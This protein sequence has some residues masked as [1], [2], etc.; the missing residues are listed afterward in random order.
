[1]G[2]SCP[3]ANK[4][5]LNMAVVRVNTHGV[6]DLPEEI[7]LESTDTKPTTT[8]TGTALPAGSTAYER[9]TGDMY[10]FNG[11]TWSLMI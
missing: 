11:S 2:L 5:G 1:M 3:S 4:G 6:V 8:V 9:N 7:I 10:L